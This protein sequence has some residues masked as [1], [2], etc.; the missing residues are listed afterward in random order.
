[1]KRQDTLRDPYEDPSSPY[2]RFWPID[3]KPPFKT[4]DEP[5]ILLGE[6]VL[7]KEHPDANLKPGWYTPFWKNKH[8]GLVI[9]T[10]WVKVDWDQSRDFY[11]V[12][13]AVVRWN[14]GE[15]TNT[16]QSLLRSIL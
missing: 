12:P 14:D 4:F 9:G 5:S 10:R 3:E 16:S 2:C 6:V 15:T 13:E 8:M 11:C 1:M 7:W